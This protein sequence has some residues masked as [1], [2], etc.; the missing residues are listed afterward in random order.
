MKHLGATFNEERQRQ[1]DMIEARMGDRKEDIAVYRKEIEEAALKAKEQDEK[2][3]Q[4]EEAHQKALLERKANLQKTLQTSQKLTYKKAYSQP[5]W[6]FNTVMHE[7]QM[8]REDMAFHLEAPETEF[9]SEV[10]QTLIERVTSL[11]T[12]L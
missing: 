2:A 3:R 8:R 6:A 7:A 12:Q 9:Q 10:K 11:E 5:L 1:L 4:D